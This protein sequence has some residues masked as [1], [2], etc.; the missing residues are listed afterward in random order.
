[1]MFRKSHRFV[2]AACLG[3]SLLLAGCGGSDEATVYQ[4]PKENPTPPVASAPPN[5]PFLNG[6]MGGGAGGS[7][8]NQSLPSGS[9]NNAAIPP[10][11]EVPASWT[12]LPATNVRLASFSVSSEAGTLDISVTSFPGDVGGFLANVNRWR[13]Q[14]GLPPASEAE[15]RGAAETVTTASGPATLV[16]LEGGET[17]T[18]AGILMHDNASWFFKMTGPTSLVQQETEAFRSFLAS[19][20]F[21]ATHGH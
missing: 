11:W 7:M 2:A 10:A 6:Q 1:M 18:L 5:A 13:N 12:E 17:S 14:I 3:T 8:A 16:S 15:A 9:L 19:A 20:D 21:A 4:V